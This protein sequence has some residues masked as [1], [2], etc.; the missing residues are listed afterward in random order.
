[1]IMWLFME[2]KLRHIK[3]VYL[4]DEC[5]PCLS[6]SRLQKYARRLHFKLHLVREGKKNGAELYGVHTP[7]FIF[8]PKNEMLSV[9]GSRTIVPDCSTSSKK[10]FL[11]VRHI[12]P[13]LYM[14]INAIVERR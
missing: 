9:L 14:Q 2:N 1:M 7:P 10:A 13:P 12:S 11:R 6:A 3:A 8:A 4:L 5:L